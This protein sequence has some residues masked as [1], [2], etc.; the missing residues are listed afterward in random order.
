MYLQLHL[1]LSFFPFSF[2]FF[3]SFSSFLLF[4]PVFPSLSSF[5]F[6]LSSPLSL[7]ILISLPFHLSPSLFLFISLH[8]CFFSSSSL[9]L[10]T[11]QVHRLRPSHGHDSLVPALEAD[12]SFVLT[13]LPGTI[14]SQGQTEVMCCVQVFGPA[15]G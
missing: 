7:F 1:H 15:K 9:S 11:E 13:N 12:L 3:F 10:H 5:I 8:L 14:G 4:S 2:F 6:S